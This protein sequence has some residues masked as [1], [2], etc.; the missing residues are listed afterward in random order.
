MLCSDSGDSSGSNKLN[1]DGKSRSKTVPAHS[2]DAI[3][4]LK[5]QTH[6]ASATANDTSSHAEK[7]SSED[8]YEDEFCDVETIEQK[9]D[10]SLCYFRGEENERMKG[11][12]KGDEF[13]FS[14]II[15]IIIINVCLYK[16]LL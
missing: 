3:L 14:F 15:I 8:P 5:Y 2:I 4:G 11:R 1:G 16:V 12:E 9:K 7:T 10:R 13:S 6:V